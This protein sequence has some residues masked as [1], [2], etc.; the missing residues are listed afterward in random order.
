MASTVSKKDVSVRT[1]V[2][3]NSTFFVFLI[4]NWCACDFVEKIGGG[5]FL[6]SNPERYFELILSKTEFILEERAVTGKDV[7]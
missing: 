2:S 6:K 1:A 3:V 5:Y 4:S 7:Q